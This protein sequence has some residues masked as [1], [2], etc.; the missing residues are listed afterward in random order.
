M[1]ALALFMIYF[2]IYI[3]VYV[4]IFVSAHARKCP[5]RL[6]EGIGTQ[7]LEWQVVGST[8]LDATTQTPDFCKTGKQSSQLS[9]PS[10]PWLLLK[11]VYEYHQ[12]HNS[13]TAVL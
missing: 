5:W 3:Y 2:C 1:I 8:W 11:A 10:S 12:S 7:A 6:Q 9:H 4:C 13:L